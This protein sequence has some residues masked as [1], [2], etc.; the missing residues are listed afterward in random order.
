M[1]PSK[2]RAPP[3]I[4]EMNDLQLL[5]H[6]ISLSGSD[7]TQ[8]RELAHA[9]LDAHQTLGQVLALSG[10]E[11]LRF[12]ELGENAAAFL[13]LLPA[14]MERYAAD[15]GSDDERPPIYLW[16]PESAARFLVPKFRDQS[17]ELVYM[18]CLGK[19]FELIT[20]TLLTKG[21]T[22]AVSCSVPKVLRLALAHSSKSVILAHNHPDGATVFSKSDLVATSI[23]GYALTTADI[24]LTDHLLLAGNEIISL[25]ELFLSGQLAG[26][27]YPFP[28]AWHDEPWPFKRMDLRKWL[29]AIEAEK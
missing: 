15:P 7:L 21:G 14:L 13:H 8:A 3:K 22:G 12:P 10:D 25:R 26:S 11:L 6:L 27:P 2:R 17:A 18:F 20:G 5:A 16:E 19:R 28:Q 29:E 1:A 4:A 24:L 23:M 9:L